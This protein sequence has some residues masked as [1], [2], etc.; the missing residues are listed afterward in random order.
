MKTAIRARVDRVRL[1]AD[2]VRRMGPAW[3]AFRIRYAAERRLGVLARR[4]PVG[5]WPAAT[6]AFELGCLVDTERLSAW[7]S[8]GASE[9]Q[10][11]EVRSTLEQLRERRFDVFGTVVG[12]TSWHHDPIHDATYE[13]GVHWSEV[14]EFE[15]V[16]VKCVWE[17]SR[18]SWAFDLARAHRLRLDSGADELFWNLVDDWMREN[19]PNAGI[20][21]ACGQEASIRLSAVLLAAAAMPESATP[22]RLA[23]IEQLVIATADRVASNIGYARSQR[24]NH[25]LSEALGLWMSSLV[26]PSHERAPR[27]RAEAERHIEEVC[28]TLVFD[29]GGTSQ[30]S[31][32]YH[33]VFLHEF[34]LVLHFAR[35]AGVAAPSSVDEA[36]QRSASYFEALMEPESGH[37]PFLG[38][39]DGAEIL[40]N[41]ASPHRRI[42]PTVVLDAAMLERPIRSLD[43]ADAEWCAWFAL[44]APGLDSEAPPSAGFQHFPEMGTVVMWSGR[45]RAYLRCG[46]LRFRPSQ[47]DQL[48][49]DI[50]DGAENLEG[51]PGTFSYNPAE[52]ERGLLD[53]AFDHNSVV[54]G[55][56][57]HMPRVGRFAFARWASGVVERLELMDGVVTGEFSLETRSGS[58]RRVVELS[59]TGVRDLIVEGQRSRRE[60]SWA[61]RGGY[62]HQR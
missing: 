29:D 5:A 39:D 15:R 56:V 8:D 51:D 36:L 46:P 45:H 24:N 60:G 28:G 25:H 23:R 12:L 43:S 35:W 40:P 6:G 2:F 49:L 19:P 38:H 7:L 14:P 32:N 30:Y 48:H 33:R 22:E 42:A 20:N 3:L 54:K 26:L 9:A 27:W 55:G 13:V 17:P 50:W 53:S 41:L 58:V 59:P 21:W 16:D 57:D 47:A 37:A 52:G 31:T 61:Y 1:L 62:R 11:A 34:V 10:R 4:S 44:D 18:F